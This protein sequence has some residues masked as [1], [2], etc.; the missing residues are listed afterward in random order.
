MEKIGG[1]QNNSRSMKEKDQRTFRPDKFSARLPFKV[2]LDWRYPTPP[3]QRGKDRNTQHP[4]KK[5][6]PR[7]N[8]IGP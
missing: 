6:L 7:E 4:L 2:V 5:T 3:E 1:K 8:P